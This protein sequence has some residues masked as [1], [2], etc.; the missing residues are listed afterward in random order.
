VQQL[1]PFATLAAPRRRC[2]GSRRRA[3]ALFVGALIAPLAAC[4]CWY[5]VRHDWRGS[6]A[7]DPRV[8]EAILRA[9]AGHRGDVAE[10]WNGDAF[11]GAVEAGPVV[12]SVRVGR[13]APGATV[14]IEAA[15]VGEPPAY[16]VLV[17]ALAEQERLLRVL[18]RGVP[19]FPAPSTFTRA[20]GGL[21][22][23]CG[24]AWA[25]ARARWESEHAR[26]RRDPEAPSR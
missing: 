21:E 5:S 9:E 12:T 2:R 11:G 15:W 14:T 25:A 26:S 16:G 24:D 13:V 18:A 17:H 4:D 19:A 1:P 3:R 23:P 6:M 7:F 10:P 8:A 20:W 22:F